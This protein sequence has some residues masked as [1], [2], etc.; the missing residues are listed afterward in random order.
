LLLGLPHAL[1]SSLSTARPTPAIYPLSLHDAL[2]ISAHPAEVHLRRSS[3]G[4]KSCHAGV[5]PHVPAGRLLGPLRIRT[6]R[7]RRTGVEPCG[8]AR[9]AAG[10]ALPHHATWA[11]L[12]GGARSGDH[13]DGKRPRSERP[14]SRPGSPSCAQS[15]GAR[16]E[17]VPDDFASES[18]AHDFRTLAVGCRSSGEII[19]EVIG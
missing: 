15:S 5:G 12:D 18:D 10:R 2:P 4:A 1:S 13:V 19:D 11:D 7:A 9:C 8:G 14:R 6:A 16:W 17:R 3:T